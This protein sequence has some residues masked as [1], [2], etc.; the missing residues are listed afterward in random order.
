MKRRRLPAKQ[1]KLCSGKRDPSDHGRASNATATLTM[2]HHTVGWCTANAIANCAADTAP[3][4]N[5][6][7]HHD[8]FP[9][10]N[11]LKLTHCCRHRCDEGLQALPAGSP[12]ACR[13][14][15]HC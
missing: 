15:P 3:F 7:W 13:V 5:G 4:S 11:E 8:S 10:P 9:P 6:C 14:R 2:T 12:V 1:L